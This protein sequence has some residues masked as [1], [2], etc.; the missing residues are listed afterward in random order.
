MSRSLSSS[1][2]LERFFSLPRGREVEP[3]HEVAF[4]LFISCLRDAVLSMLIVYDLESP[5][6][7]LEHGG[8]VIGN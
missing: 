2:P 1:H 5:L 6:A 4:S 7:Q 8:L 3:K